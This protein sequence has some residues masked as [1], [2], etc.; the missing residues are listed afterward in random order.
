[1][2]ISLQ[3]RGHPGEGNQQLYR[4]GMPVGTR[5]GISG[6][7]IFPADGDYALTIGDLALGRD[8]PLM[9]FDN[10]VVALLDG[11]EFFRTHIGGERDQR[12]PAQ[13]PLSC[14]AGTAPG[15]CHLRAP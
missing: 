13:H 7:Y 1:M 5:G 4:D 2:V 10:T 8:V 15:C 14:P 11:K 9:E 12:S 3:V 6:E